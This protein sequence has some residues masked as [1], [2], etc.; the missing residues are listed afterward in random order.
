MNKSA[1]NEA[2]N[3]QQQVASSSPSHTHEQFLL[4]QTQVKSLTMQQ[5]N[6]EKEKQR[7]IRKCNILLGNVEEKTP[8]SILE[9]VK[10][11][12]EERMNVNLT[13]LHAGRL[14]KPKDGQKRLILVKMK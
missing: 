3:V 2:T 1:D 10:N 5:Q 7:E 11:I 14:G 9:T 8:E 12:F 4:L 13:P 6:I